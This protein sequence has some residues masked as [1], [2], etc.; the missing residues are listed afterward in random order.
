MNIFPLVGF[1][2]GQ[3]DLLNIGPHCIHTLG[4]SPSTLCNSATEVMVYFARGMLNR[5]A[6]YID[7][8]LVQ[9]LGG[10]LLYP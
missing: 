4:T 2:D 5:Q 6:V 9:Y 7:I 3:W 8:G 1:R 10:Q